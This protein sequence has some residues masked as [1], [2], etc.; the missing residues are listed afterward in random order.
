LQIYAKV[1]FSS[2]KVFSNTIQD[3][4]LPTTTDKLTLITKDLDIT[5]SVTNYDGDPHDPSKEVPQVHPVG[6]CDTKGVCQEIYQDGF[7][8]NGKWPA[9]ETD[10]VIID[11]KPFEADISFF[12]NADS[13]H[14][15]VK[16]IIIDPDTGVPSDIQKSNGNFWNQRGYFTGGMCKAG[17]CNGSAVPCQKDIECS[18]KLLPECTTD[19]TKAPSFGYILNKTCDLHPYVAT[20]YYNCKGAAEDPNSGIWHPTCDVLTGAQKKKWDDAK[21]GGCC[22]YQPKVQVLD[23]WGW[24]NGTCD[25]S[26][27]GADDGTPGCYDGKV[28][29][30]CSNYKIFTNT[31]IQAHPNTLFKARVIVPLNKISQ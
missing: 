24:C 26:K 16:R 25:D 9:S 21:L 15:P 17:V 28:I 18:G 13:N 10:N 3:Y 20:V 19:E 7:N 2:I 5:A 12:Y 6:D 27:T 23:N 31:S 8:I 29:N 14:M 11:T 30:E 4:V 1:P 22:V